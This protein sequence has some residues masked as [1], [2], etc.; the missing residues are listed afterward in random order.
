[1]DA[2]KE[3]ASLFVSPHAPLSIDP[4][5]HRMPNPHIGFTTLNPESAGENFWRI[6][7]LTRANAIASKF[8]AIASGP[9]LVVT[10]YVSFKRTK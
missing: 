9:R 6:T 7:L 5:S 2:G 1:M 3:R 4:N 8:S 10:F